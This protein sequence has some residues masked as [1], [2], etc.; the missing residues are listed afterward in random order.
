MKINYSILI[1]LI[2]ILNAC[3]KDNAPMVSNTLG[4]SNNTIVI[5]TDSVFNI[6]NYS[7]TSG[8]NVISDG[9]SPIL[10]RGVCWNTNINPTINNYHTYDFVGLGIFTSS[11]S[12]L[13]PGTTYHLRAYAFNSIDT[14]YG[15]EITF[16]TTN[17]GLGSC[18]G[19]PAII[20]DIDGNIYN[21]VSIGNQ[22]WM[23][24]SLK[25]SRY[26]N[27]SPIQT[28]LTDSQWQSV[29][30]GACADNNNNLNYTST[31]GKL[32]NWYAVSDGSGLCP[33][34]W[35]VA[36]ESDWNQLVK[37]IDPLADTSINSGT[38][39]STA[40]GSMKATIGW[41]SPNIGA[42]NSSSFSGLPGGFRLYG[43]GSY[44][45][46]GTGGYWWSSTLSTTNYAYIHKLYFQDATVKKVMDNKHVGY[47]VRCV[48][49]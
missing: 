28:G 49:D 19:G 20:S 1:A 29:T 15:N 5:T 37:S 33:A 26:K 23:K 6:S 11:L 38:Q 35:H 18:S 32:Y 21:V 31:Y 13:V 44:A 34:G 40:G 9:G 7:A 41:T 3:S 25:T 2:L 12:N 42:T 10:K 24:E 43:G 14:I 17:I 46:P 27:G 4:S 22:C 45:L 16:S 8:G 48:R 47:S 36:T 39:S 30:S